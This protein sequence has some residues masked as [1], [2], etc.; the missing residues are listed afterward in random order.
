MKKIRYVGICVVL[1]T[2]AALF[3]W[4]FLGKKDFADDTLL[5][6]GPVVPPESL[7][8]NTE[9]N[10]RLDLRMNLRGLQ[11]TT[12]KLVPWK[13][14]IQLADPPADGM[15]SRSEIKLYRA[16]LDRIGIMG[17]AY[18]QGI[19]KKWLFTLR[20]AAVELGGSSIS[21]GINNDWSWNSSPNLVG[22]FTK[23][24]VACVPDWLA[25]WVLNVLLKDFLEGFNQT[26]AIPFRP[27]VD[28]VWKM[29]NQDLAITDNPRVVVGLR[30]KAVM[31]GGPIIDEPTNDLVVN[32]GVDMQSWCSIDS[33]GSGIHIHPAGPL[34]DLKKTG[35]LPSSTRLQ[36]P[37]ILNIGDMS[38]LFQPQTFPVNDGK[39]NVRS[40]DLS[41]KDGMLYAKLHVA[42]DIPTGFLSVFPKT[43]RGTLMVQAKP[44]CDPSTGELQLQDLTLTAKSDSILV[45]LL[46][47][48]AG[49]AFKRQIELLLP[50]LSGG[51]IN[52][53]N[54]TINQEATKFLMTQIPQ[55]AGSV[56]DFSEQIRSARPT[57]RNVHLMPQN[58]SAKQGYLIIV[59][60]ANADLGLSID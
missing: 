46:G 29:A 43:V 21:L 19:L 59:I 14:P 37:F 16:G 3:C 41:E 39:V 20:S 31:L 25:A 56:P 28:G 30:P 38:R 4:R 44:S 35:V 45:E 54:A 33:A 11:E 24:D 40:L 47:N 13:C 10:I 17:T 5:P 7:P 2:F 26:G 15:L 34:P 32:I 60:L 27:L 18:F 48:G 42:I 58:I 52:R 1:L 50:L 51:F 9:S 8:E 23:A 12:N 22:K 53:V 6:Q 49:M 57:V 55:W 36:L